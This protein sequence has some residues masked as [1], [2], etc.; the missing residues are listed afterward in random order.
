MTLAIVQGKEG[1]KMDGCLGVNIGSVT[2]KC[3]VIT[4]EGRP[5]LK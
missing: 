2:A 4:K 1:L 5:L 3:A